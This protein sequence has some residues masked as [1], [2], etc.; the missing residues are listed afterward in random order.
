MLYLNNIVKRM[1]NVG[2]EMLTL[3]KLL[4]QDCFIIS[5]L[6]CFVIA[7]VKNIVYLGFSSKII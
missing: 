5:I 7:V 2:A 3:W 6:K 1:G 4:F